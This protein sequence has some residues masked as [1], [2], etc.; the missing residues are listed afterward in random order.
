M[1][2]STVLLLI[3]AFWGVSCFL[4]GKTKSYSRVLSSVD[5]KYYYVKEDMNISS[6]KVKADT[7]A[8]V[9]KNITKLIDHL[10][11]LKN[12][13][14]D[15]NII[16]LK[17]R[18]TLGSLYENIYPD[19]HNTTYTINKGEQIAVCLENSRNFNDLNFVL[20][21]ELSHIGCESY[22]HNE[23]FKKFFSF[24]LEKSIEIGI[25]TYQDYSKNPSDY[26]GMIIN[27]TPVK[28]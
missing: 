24:L 15:K 1:N 7:L 3:I 9:N 19:A 22:G 2:D 13:P 20:I 4:I 5:N 16:L 17:D 8:K 25:Y 21:H 23:E 18:Y 11:Q 14:F 26:C 28:K 6:M 12:T 10:S 27:N